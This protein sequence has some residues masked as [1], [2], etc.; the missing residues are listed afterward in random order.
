MLLA[1]GAHLS[2]GGTL[3]SSGVL[4][5]AGFLVGLTS[6]TATARR[7]RLAPLLALLG[8]EQ[9]LLH[10]VFA[11]ASMVWTPAAMHASAGHAAATTGQLVADR[12]PAVMGPSPLMAASHLVATVATAWLLA[13]GEDWLWGLGE[14]AVR[15][16]TAA[17]S[18]RR[19][20]P[21]EARASARRVLIARIRG[22]AAGAR[23]PPRLGPVRLAAR[24]ARSVW[25]AQPVW[26]V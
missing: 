24:P 19:R 11:A 21:R 26:S 9:L 3:P 12:L 6:V 4:V 14:R 2:G 8:I 13:H 23:G 25:L 17:P 1:T 18:P 5:V 20:R 15:A 7:I 22:G 16:A 10:E